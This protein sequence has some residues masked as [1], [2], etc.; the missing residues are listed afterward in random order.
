MMWSASPSSV[1]R[2]ADRDALAD[3][4]YRALLAVPGSRVVGAC[5]ECWPG[6]PKAL[7]KK[8]GRDLGA[9]DR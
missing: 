8:C 9:A 3:A 4:G 6:A 7:C 5:S 1:S 2:A